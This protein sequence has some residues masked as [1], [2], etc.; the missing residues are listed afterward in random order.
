MEDT[1]GSLKR[2]VAFLPGGGEAREGQVRLAEAVGNSIESGRH[3]IAQAGTGTGKS[4]A[5]LVPAIL[6]GKKVV[7]AT[8]TKALQDQLAEKDLPFLARTM[9]R[10]FSFAVLKGRSNYVCVQ[11]CSEVVSGGEQAGFEDLPGPASRTGAGSGLFEEV[12]RLVDFRGS[13]ESGDRAEL[14]FEPSPRAW[15]LVSVTADECPGA[16]SCDSGQDCFAEKARR[17]AGEADVVVVNMHLYG[18]HLASGGV[19]L[20]EH[21]AVIFDEAHEL[22]DVLVS[23]LGA[24]ISPGRIRHVAATGRTAVGGPERGR[25]GPA[26]GE[27]AVDALFRAADL[28][29]DV[30]EGVA[31][32]RIASPGEGELGDTLRLLDAR[33]VAVAAVLRAASNEKADAGKEPGGD[34]AQRRTRAILA[35]DNLVEDARTAASPAKDD[36]VFVEGSARRATLRVAPI[37]VGARLAASVFES[38][39]TV[40]TSATIPP[41]LASRLGLPDADHDE[42][43]VGSPFH[44]DEHALLY[45]ATH[46]PQR[47]RGSYGQPRQPAGD[48]AADPSDAARWKELAALIEAAGGRTLALFTSWRAME[49]AVTALRGM[50]GFEILAQGDLPK[51]AL[52]ARF[53]DHPESCLFATM[54]FWQGLDVPGPTLSLVVIDKIPFPRPD[55][56]LTEARRERAGSAAFSVVDLPRAA[57]LLAQGAGRLIRTATDRGVVAVLDPRLAKAT[58]RW[59]LVKALP[60]MRRTKDLEEVEGFLRAL[61][62]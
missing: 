61:R 39:P 33:A 11:R 15:S 38:T 62:S 4:L 14:D 41:S 1:A 29:E 19:V 37:D 22:E 52:V 31:G 58:Y 23:A 25:R 8:A 5:Y 26:P 35:L 7:V 43:D 24:E 28:L 60:P 47:A 50:V 40:L 59:T 27:E 45:C 48:P 10:T 13:T 57:T 16:A 53:S 34:V 36:V 12:R 20:P 2:V 46:L 56:P 49:Q 21:E 51:P 44:Y 42:L 55:D 17:R 3:L 6:S 32:K 54:S 9:G 18:A 30:L